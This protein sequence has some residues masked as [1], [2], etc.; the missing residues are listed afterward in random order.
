MGSAVRLVECVPNFSEGRRTEVVDAIAAAVATVEGAH[1]LDRTMDASHNRSVVTFA[2]GADAVVQA[3]EAAVATAIELIDMERH[4]GE[5]PR[6]GA[7]DVMPFVPLDVTPMDEVVELARDFGR[8]VAERFEIPVYLYA[9]AALRP[10]R[11]RLADLRRGG[12]ELLRAEIGSDPLRAPD[13]G[14]ARTHP[15]AGAIAVGAR[16]PL[17]AFNLN[18]RTDDLALAQRIARTIRESSGGLPAV[19][20]KGFL[21]ESP[22]GRRTAQVS[23]N[24][25]DWQRTGIPAVVREVRRLAQEA[26]T[27]LDRCELIGLAPAGALREVAG[28]AL[29]ISDLSADQ[30]LEL[31]LARLAA[32]SKPRW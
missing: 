26:G 7:A 1:V 4:I 28:D 6:I 10:E 8:R 31:R 14:P 21:V 19:Q 30:A 24:L 23:T 18:L 20:A 5:H 2:G 27:E 16:P 32:D 29:G 22:E 17:I 25:L 3:A 15:T 9:E 12:Y 13:F 11:R